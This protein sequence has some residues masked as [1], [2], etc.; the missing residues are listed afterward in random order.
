MLIDGRVDE[1]EL[2]NLLG[3]TFPPSALI[4]NSQNLRKDYFKKTYMKL[5]DHND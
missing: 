4:G 5:K 1:L 3:M 2:R